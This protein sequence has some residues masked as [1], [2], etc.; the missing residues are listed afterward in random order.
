MPDPQD[1]YFISSS[2]SRIV[3]RELGLQEQEPDSLLAGT[4]LRRG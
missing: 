2:H 4:G 1:S 3:A